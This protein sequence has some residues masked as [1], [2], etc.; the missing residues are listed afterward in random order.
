MINIFCYVIYPVSGV[1]GSATK[2]GAASY[3]PWPDFQFTGL[4]RPYPVVSGSQL[5]DEEMIGS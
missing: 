1:A 5:Q 4:L 2:G 3:D